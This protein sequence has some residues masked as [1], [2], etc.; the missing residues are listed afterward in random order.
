MPGRDVSDP[1]DISNIQASPSLKAHRAF[2]SRKIERARVIQQPSSASNEQNSAIYTNERIN[3]WI[4]ASAAVNVAPT[5]AASSTMPLNL[6]DDFRSWNADPILKNRDFASRMNGGR[7]AYS[8]T[9]DNSIQDSPITSNLT[10]PKATKLVEEELREFSPTPPKAAKQVEEESRDFSDNRTDS[11]KTAHEN[12]SSDGEAGEAMFADSPSMHASRKKWLKDSGLGKSK[13]IGLGLGLDTD[14]DSASTPGM[15][16]PKPKKE[17]E[18]EDFIAFDGAWGGNTPERIHDQLKSDLR[19]AKVEATPLVTDQHASPPTDSDG[20]FNAAVE[21]SP[22]IN[23]SKE[24]PGHASPTN[25]LERQVEQD[26]L[27]L[28]KEMEQID[29][30]IEEVNRNRLS[31]AST[32]STVVA[33]MVFDCTPQRRQTLRHTGKM[34]DSSSSSITGKRSSM[35]SNASTPRSLKRSDRKHEV[36]LRQSFSADR[37]PSVRTIS[38]KRNS[39]NNPLIV[40][41]DRR[42]SLRSS[43]TSGQPLSKTFS[44]TSKQQSSR[45]TTAPEEATSY[46]DVPR[47]DHNQTVSVIIQQA[48]AVKQEDMV[49]KAMLSP[50]AGVT[51]GLAS[52]ALSTATSMTSNGMRTHY[53]PQSP[54]IQREGNV[55]DSATGEASNKR[56]DPAV[57]GDWS[58]FRPHPTMVTPFSLRSQTSS[59]PGT[60]EVNEATALSIHPHTNKSI[61][62]IQEIAGKDKSKREQSAIIAGNA[63]IAIPAALNPMTVN[64]G[65]AMPQP[66][67]SPLQ[68]PRDPPLPPD[69]INVIPP[70]PANVPPPL[71]DIGK[72]PAPVKTGRFS[73]LK[74]A[75][76]A[77]RYSDV[78]GSSLTRRLSERYSGGPRFSFAEDDEKESRL[79]PSWRPRRLYGG[80]D[81][82]N[83]SESEF[84]NDGLLPSSRASRDSRPGTQ[85]QGPPSRSMSLSNR[86]SSRLRSGSLRR[87]RRASSVS[88]AARP[89]TQ[90]LPYEVVDTSVHRRQPL[91]RRL[92]GSL[93]LPRPH[94]PQPDFEFLNSRQDDAIN[95]NVRRTPGTG[96]QLQFS[97]FRGI[98]EKMEKRRE[99]KEEE[100]REARSDKLKE[101]I[102]VVGPEE[103]P[104]GNMRLQ[105]EAGSSHF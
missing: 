92:T 75:V 26:G 45:P 101:Q 6:T 102:N 4:P 31:Q 51:P 84:G 9:Q 24:S 90:P 104:M 96:Y 39:V 40:I 94:R 11:F 16:T 65:P 10:P 87:P 22:S 81:H 13:N 32:N 89:A 57:T 68:N 37:Q 29:A 38:T 103:G 43:V 14:E 21:R 28:S 64:P 33:A 74:R 41:P 56:S 82:D 72:A 50:L 34:Q 52:N 7:D 23:G 69:I 61:L 49:D 85:N 93:R 44:T 2:P 8:S 88:A 100:K 83:D 73:N 12:I 5:V 77:R 66:I 3:S 86:L 20:L 59:T 55:S 17:R 91:V 54:P 63:N 62:V 76:S 58:N 25:S 19:R 71:E 67:D 70:T 48:R 105:H 98:W 53:V 99:A 79:H 30:E 95:S 60:L 36:T 1:M 27:P 35:D 42:S 78:L 97:G 80:G 18:S 15:E 47:E 46:F